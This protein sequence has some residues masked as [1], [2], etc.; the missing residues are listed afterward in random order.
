MLAGLL[1]DW[2][3]IDGSG[4]SP[5]VQ[6][7]ARW[8][9]VGRCGDVTFWL[10]VRAVANPGAGAVRLTYE[11]SPTTDESLF[12]ALAASIT[13]TAS[14]TPV[15]TKIRLADSAAVP[16]GRWARWKV[17]GTAAGNWSLSF[18]VLTVGG[19]GS[20]A[21]A[22]PSS[23]PLTGWWRASY[24]GSPWV[25]TAS[26]GASGS[27]DLTE[28]TNPAGAGATQNGY[29][30]AAFDGIVQELSNGLAMSN[31]VSLGAGTAIALV[32]VTSAPATTTP[33]QDPGIWA[34]AGDNVLLTFSTSGAAAC[35]FDGV[36]QSVVVPCS[37]AAYHLLQMKWDGSD[38]K[39]R[40][41]SGTWASTSCGAV[42]GLP[43]GLVVGKNPGWAFLDSQVLELMF[44]SSTLSDD[45]CD[46]VKSYINSRY[47]LSL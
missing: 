16:L 20:Q 6:D 12:V 24:S 9:D 41:D 29:T 21:S 42:A 22:D 7:R 31:F 33:H 3:T 13:L 15:I 34:E 23:L 36:Q 17:E 39:L 18:R 43:N 1:T 27:R 25:G 26:A 37:T 32:N 47:A 14:A 4:T 38:L 46:T 2:T 11:T 5:F 8:L 28:A 45:E 10:E 40:V 30:P 44:S 35:I 19:Q